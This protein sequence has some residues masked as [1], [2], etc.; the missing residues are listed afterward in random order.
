MKDFPQFPVVGI[1]GPSS[2]GSELHPAIVSSSDTR[3]E[4]LMDASVLPDKLDKD[5]NVIGKEA[6]PGLVGRVNAHVFPDGSPAHPVV[7]IPLFES[8]EHAA[9]AAEAYAKAGL[10]FVGAYWTQEQPKMER[11]LGEIRK[12]LADHAEQISDLVSKHLPAEPK[13]AEGEGEGQ[14]AA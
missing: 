9:A 13:P 12:Q 4:G 11:V 8:F 3:T 7:G 10:K 14:K 6:M 2:N 5:G 1:I